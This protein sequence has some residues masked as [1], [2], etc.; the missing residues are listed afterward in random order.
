MGAVLVTGA[1]GKVGRAVVQHVGGGGREVRPFDLA[2]GDDLR[3]EEQVAAAMMGCDA[4][5]HAGALAH[6]SAG[7]PADIMATNVLGT[8]HVLLAAERGDVARVVHFSSAQV[9]GLTDGEHEVRYLPV[10]DDHPLLAS[11]PYGLSKR[12]AETMCEAW[13]TRTGIPTVVLR[14][15][16]ILDDADRR[17]ANRSS[18]SGA[19]VHLDDVVSA[20]D[21]ALSA[22]VPPHVRLT[23]S[24]TDDFDCSKAQQVLGWTARHR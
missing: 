11:R 16:M 5:V 8:W 20:V 9:F 6:D 13:T 7:T 24:G 1:L 4:V 12:L 18:A 23:L 14:P 2:A 15:V 22:D 17:L 10:D 19:Y 3:S 21:L